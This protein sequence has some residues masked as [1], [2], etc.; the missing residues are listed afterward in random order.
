MLT[1]ENISGKF[2]SASNIQIAG[3]VG[4]VQEFYLE[5]PKNAERAL[6]AGRC[7]LNGLSEVAEL[8]NIP[9]VATVHARHANNPYSEW[10]Q[11]GSMRERRHSQEDEDHN[12]S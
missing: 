11:R 1:H 7:L 9:K 5:L 12:Q 4:L 10:H 8:Q 6:V 2:I 3:G